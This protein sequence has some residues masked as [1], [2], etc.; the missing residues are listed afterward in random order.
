MNPALRGLYAITPD[1]HFTGAA[2]VDAVEA[3]LLGGARILQYRDKGPDSD[4]RR[5]EAAALRA[6]CARHG[7]LFLVNDDVALA[8]AVEAD[9]VHLGRDD[10]DIAAARR[11][12]PPG[13]VIGASCYDR[14]DL[15]QQASAAG[16]DYVAFGSF[17]PSPT[18]PAAVRA[19]AELLRRARREL[20]LP[21]VAI[22]GISPENGAA[23][24]EAG[25]AMLAVISALFDAADI[26]AAA[27]SFATCFDTFPGD[28]P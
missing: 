21:A 25:A 20:A 15:A 12:L 4:R 16:A 18:K 28:L 13:A 8:A 11:R 24:V 9:G 14:F 5:T 22:G 23:L 2:L 26:R 10:L 3:C 19:D 1:R 6:L 27:Q 17:H 7:A